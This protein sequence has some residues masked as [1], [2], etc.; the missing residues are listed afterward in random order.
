MAGTG[1]AAAGREG[2]QAVRWWRRIVDRYWQ[3]RA[4]ERRVAE[5]VR[6]LKNRTDD[7]VSAADV[8]MHDELLQGY[9]AIVGERRRR[10][11]PHNLERRR[12]T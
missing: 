3:K 7:A 10:A 9:E 12:G 11:I 4:E 6:A 5:Q 8:A 2:H 1:R